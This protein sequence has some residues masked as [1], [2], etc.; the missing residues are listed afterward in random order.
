MI[1]SSRPGFRLTVT[2]IC[3]ALGIILPVLILLA[4]SFMGSLERPTLTDALVLCG[5]VWAVLACVL[6]T[7]Y[8]EEQL[9]FEGMLC[10]LWDTSRRFRK[11]LRLIRVLVFALLGLAAVGLIVRW[12]ASSGNDGLAGAIAVACLLA[13][14]GIVWLAVRAAKEA[15][16][17]RGGTYFVHRY[18]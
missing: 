4:P 11:I 8:R 7:A 16:H 14:I 13:T 12:A 10:S 2:V 5:L 18:R 9:P 17:G 1:K 3:V 6:W 15:L